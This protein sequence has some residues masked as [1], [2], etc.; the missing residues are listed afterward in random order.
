MTVAGGVTGEQ[1]AVATRT[2]A[3]NPMSAALTV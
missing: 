1:D 2:P 3:R